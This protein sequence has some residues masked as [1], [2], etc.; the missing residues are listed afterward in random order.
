RQ[1]VRVAG[2]DRRAVERERPLVD[3]VP[4]QVEGDGGDGRVGLL[5]GQLR[6]DP[7]VNVHLAGVVGEA[8]GLGVVVVGRPAAGR[9][10][11]LRFVDGLLEADAALV[12]VDEPVAGR[13]HFEAY[14]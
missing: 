10:P 6:A 11:A 5:A 2:P 7:R 1:G 13:P 9:V 14:G 8:V 4:L 12:Q 3:A